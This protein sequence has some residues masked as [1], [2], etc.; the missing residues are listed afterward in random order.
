MA[1]QENRKYGW[2]TTGKLIAAV[3]VETFADR[4]DASRKYLYY[5]HRD[6]TKRYLMT[7]SV[8]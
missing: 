6:N 3:V 5:D 2:S 1:C 8:D 4:R 7:M